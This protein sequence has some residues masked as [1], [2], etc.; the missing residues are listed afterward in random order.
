[1]VACPPKLKL[2]VRLNLADF[3]RLLRLPRVSTTPSAPLV[4]ADF[5]EPCV[6]FTSAG[7]NAGDLVEALREHFFQWTRSP[8]Q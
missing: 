7:V 6:W 4:R 3:L 5:L 8:G 2:T 1:M